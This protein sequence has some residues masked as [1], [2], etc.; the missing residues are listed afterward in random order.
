MPK[1]ERDSVHTM[2]DLAQ[3]TV[4]K[5]EQAV[6]TSQQAV[7]DAAIAV[8]EGLDDLRSS[9]ESA[10][11][12]AAAQADELTRR[13]LAQ[14]RHASSVVREKAQVTGDR[15]ISYIRDEPVKALF[16]AAAAGALLA[17]MLGRRSR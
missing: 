7:N 8:N 15:T 4:S 10:L 13:G 5:A 3:R 17:L 14:A 9:S 2:S 16:I 12:R 11:I 1:T 6:E